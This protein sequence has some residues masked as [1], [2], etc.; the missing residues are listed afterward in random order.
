MTSFNAGSP[1]VSVIIP[2]LAEGDRIQ[3][4]LSQLATS[5]DSVP[6][7]VIVVDGDPQ[8]STLRCLPPQ[9]LDIRGILA[10]RGRGS[11][12]NAG[13]ALA[14]G[15]ILLFLHADTQLPPQALPKICATLRESSAVAGAFDLAIDSSR[16]ILKLIGRVSSLRSRLTRT[17]Y[18]D[19]AI[20]IHRSTFAKIGGY[21]EIP[22]MEDVALMRYLKRRGFAIVILSDR[23]LVSPRR[24]EQ[25]GVIYCTLRNWS[26]LLLYNLGVSPHQLVRWYHPTSRA[27][28]K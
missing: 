16:W 6:Y 21:P 13:A 7:E 4:L 25:E 15:A 20:F 2:V 9:Q 14:R 26:L 1:D 10:P 8:G 11:Q 18:G 28:R 3:S 12:M 19:Q 24:W 23:T 22:I 27:S 5:A 17:P